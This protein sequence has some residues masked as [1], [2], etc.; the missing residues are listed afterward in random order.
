MQADEQIKTVGQLRAALKQVQNMQSKQALQ[1]VKKSAMGIVLGLTQIGNAVEIAKFA[2][3]LVQV[4]KSGRRFA[5]YI[6]NLN[7]PNRA[8][9]YKWKQKNTLQRF[10]HIDPQLSQ[11]LDDAIQNQFLEYLQQ[12]IDKMH[13]DDQL[14]DLSSILRA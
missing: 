13:D 11:I 1:N 8:K 10:L 6:A 4:T 14:Q 12:Y 3:E 5:K 2:G 7:Q 9:Q